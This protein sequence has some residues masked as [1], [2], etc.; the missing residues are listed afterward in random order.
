MNLKKGFFRVYVV[1]TACWILF[2]I[3]LGLEKGA[4]IGPIV[5]MVVVPPVA[6]Y[7][8]L[9]IV[10]PWIWRGFKSGG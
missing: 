1:V 3:V 5:L 8:M 6:A 4:D 9:F 2:W 10:V 7:V